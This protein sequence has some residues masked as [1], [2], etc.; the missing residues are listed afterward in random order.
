[1]L[2]SSPIPRF[3]SAVHQFA[4]RVLE[5]RDSDLATLEDRTR[6]DT[7]LG[8][9]FVDRLAT[10][11][12]ERIAAGNPFRPEALADLVVAGARV[13]RANPDLDS[14]QIVTAGQ[15]AVA[16]LAEGHPTS[17]VHLA[18]E[19]ASLA[20]GALSPLLFARLFRSALRQGDPAFIPL[21]REALPALKSKPQ[22][23]IRVARLASCALPRLA[24][25]HPA[26]VSA[27]LQL[28]VPVLQGSRLPVDG[29]ALSEAL[30]IGLAVAARCEART[31]GTLV[32]LAANSLP[33][34]RELQG[35]AVQTG[36]G[37][38]PLLSPQSASEAA[39][40]LDTLLEKS[41][42]SPDMTAALVQAKMGI[43]PDM[44]KQSGLGAVVSALSNTRKHLRRSPQAAQAFVV[45][46]F[47][48]YPVGLGPTHDGM[49][50][51]LREL[52]AGAETHPVA[53]VTFVQR[54]LANLSK[55][56]ASL[57]EA[58]LSQEEGTPGFEALLVQ[59]CAA[60]LPSLPKTRDGLAD[61]VIGAVSERLS[62]GNNILRGL[63]QEALFGSLPQ[64]TP[65]TAGPVIALLGTVATYAVADADLACA[66]L[67]HGVAQLPAIRHHPLA[68]ELGRHMAAVLA[69]HPDLTPDVPDAL[70][71]SAV[72]DN[73]FALPI[74][75]AAFA[76]T[77]QANDQS[78]LFEGGLAA[79][80]VL[81]VHH[82]RSGWEAPALATLSAL[83]DLAVT[84]DQKRQMVDV[85]MR[86]ACGA[87]AGNAGSLA[88]LLGK[89][90]PFVPC[91]STE[92]GAVVNTGLQAAF[93]A[94]QWGDV[95][96]VRAFTHALAAHHNPGDPG[97]HPVRANS[98]AIITIRLRP[99]SGQRFFP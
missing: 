78:R 86:V 59:G 41:S 72:S 57:F 6:G 35:V 18:G 28:V 29:V 30:Q 44:E 52:V 90:V 83:A 77:L 24:V 25:Q 31:A 50:D 9:V 11:L 96:A 8:Q 17:A 20:P 80:E 71:R 27:L 48:H 54:G 34:N 63:C 97:L 93:M 19:V 76:G 42:P 55:G 88:G 82:A 49:R 67:S 43:L 5:G 79:V 81:S 40:L 22:R 7:D 45:G 85:A 10:V 69:Q 62:A 99:E 94:G 89:L 51:F 38:A 39:S 1:M 66:F 4:L 92:R 2:S 64:T 61:R 14:A 15:A 65:E 56:G 23:Q 33:T 73:P 37:L 87:G 70:S 36:L 21:V 98:V 74:L 53:Q 47:A 60:A 58:I 75:C 16:F 26:Q 46:A 95:G 91:G 13:A 32:K 3:S 68:Q 84:P 12:Q